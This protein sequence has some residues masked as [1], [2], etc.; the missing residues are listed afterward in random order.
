VKRRLA[1][2]IAAAL[3]VGI[4][5]GVVLAL[6]PP[7]GKNKDV[8]AAAVRLPPV[9]PVRVA[10]QAR[11]NY[12]DTST[13]VAHRSIKIEA[14]TPDPRGGP[15]W[16]VRTYSTTRYIKKRARRPGVG[17]LTGHYSCVQLGRVYQGQFG[18]MNPKG[19]F[20]PL[21]FRSSIQNNCRS[22]GDARLAKPF[23]QFESLIADP[24]QGSSTVYQTAVWGLA[25]RG[26]KSATLFL[27]DKRVDVQ[28]SPSRAF[29]HIDGGDLHESQ[30]SMAVRRAD[31][32]VERA[33]AGRRQSVPVVP[34]G[35]PP[36]LRD[37]F[38]AKPIGPSHVE[39]RTAD[40]GGGLPWGM[41]S[42]RSSE[43]GWCLSQPGRVIGDRVGTPKARAGTMTES[44]ASV[45]QCQ[46]NVRS[47]RSAPVRL[48]WTYQRADDELSST[49][50]SARRTQ[51]QRIIFSGTVDPDVKQ[52]TIATPR[53][54]RTLVPSSQAH[55]LLI[56]YDGDFPTGE[57]VMTSTFKDGHTVEQR[58]G[59]TPF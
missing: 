14:R 26:A 49:Q 37:Q 47:N 51:T 12:G 40:P 19:V 59:P 58:I 17:A 55:A 29:L 13:R 28:L 1:V 46:A 45:F 44:V 57:I 39:V 22:R 38:K 16:A 21:S 9:N 25:G 54:V 27:H 30:V 36:E 10:P 2:F 15:D 5:V 41:T 20:K 18:W 32:R 43:G 33:T 3:A 7:G 31:G 53:D 24:A 6:A 34:P 23:L 42:T 35:L 52:V 8:A 50:R 48:G 11:Q 4:V 56:A